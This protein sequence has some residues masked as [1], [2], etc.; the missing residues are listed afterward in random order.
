[1]YILIKMFLTI[2]SQS[3][4]SP[5][6]RHHLHDRCLLEPLLRYV[7]DEVAI[8]AAETEEAA[9]KALKLIKVDYEVLEPILDPRKSEGHSSI[10]HP[11]EDIFCSL[12]PM[13]M[14]I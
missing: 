7:G 13:G 9:E 1:M 6:W 11:E 8:I 3:A 12:S 4:V 5:I 14:I 2:D 10:I